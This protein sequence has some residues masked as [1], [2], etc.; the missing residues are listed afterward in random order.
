MV[1]NFTLGKIEFEKFHDKNG[2][3]RFGQVIYVD[4]I[5]CV[6]FWKKNYLSELKDD[7]RNF[8][9]SKPLR[10]AVIIKGKQ[11]CAY[12]N[13]K[14]FLKCFLK[15]DRKDLKMQM[16]QQRINPRKAT[17][18]EM[19]ALMKYINQIYHHEE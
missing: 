13:K 18:L 14:S 3:E 12:K 19:Q 2:E 4:S 7:K 6:Y 16:R 11:V 15:E 8:S 9:F 10:D 5:S 1:D 17:D